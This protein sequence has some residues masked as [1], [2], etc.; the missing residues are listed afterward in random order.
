M[1]FIVCHCCCPCT[2]LQHLPLLLVTDLMCKLGPIVGR[3]ASAIVKNGGALPRVDGRVDIPGLAALGTN[4]QGIPQERGEPVEE[5]KCTQ[6]NVYNALRDAQLDPPV[7]RGVDFDYL[8]R[9][10][11]EGAGQSEYRQEFTSLARRLLHDLHSKS[12]YSVEL[13]EVVAVLRARAVAIAQSV[14]SGLLSGSG[15]EPYAFGLTRLR[16]YVVFS[17][18]VLTTAGGYRAAGRVPELPDF[19]KGLSTPQLEEFYVQYFVEELAEYCMDV[20]PGDAMGAVM[21]SYAEV[22]A[23]TYLHVESTQ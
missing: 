6:E 9:Q 13:V 14:E 8:L 4:T 3:K 17:T 12:R 23:L 10:Y 11:A 19:Y 18:K 22:G 1:P 2:L 7:Q 21:L 16:A 5:P 20:R 15:L